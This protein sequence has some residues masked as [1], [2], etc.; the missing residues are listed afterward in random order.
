LAQDDWEKRIHGINGLISQHESS[1]AKN[2]RM[3][4]C[5]Y[6]QDKALECKSGSKKQKMLVEML[7][8]H[9]N[10]PDDYIANRCI[11]WLREFDRASFNDKAIEILREK[12]KNNPSAQLIYLMGKIDPEFCIKHTKK[13]VKGINFNAKHIGYDRARYAA[14]KVRAR[15][16]DPRYI[17]L[18][19]DTWEYY[20]KDMG[21]LNGFGEI[22]YIPRFEVVKYLSKKVRSNKVIPGAVDYPTFSYADEACRLLKKMLVGFPKSKNDGYY[23]KEDFPICLKWLSEQKKYIFR[24]PAPNL[25]VAELDK[26]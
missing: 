5:G 12:L 15:C 18:A 2:L 4:L 8:M 25:N 3:V 22:E 14:V 16:G 9:T 21:G 13:W 19:L 11:Q 6:V 24:D 1:D 26:D 23:T 17:K 20:D 7:A 10:D